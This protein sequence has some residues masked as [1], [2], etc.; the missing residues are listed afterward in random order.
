MSLPAETPARESTQAMDISEAQ[1]LIREEH[2]LHVPKDDPVM[3]LVTLL[4][5]FQQDQNAQ[6]G[7]TIKDASKDF[8]A[9]IDEMRS[10]MRESVGD[11]NEAVIKSNLA[12][13]LAEVTE[14]ARISNDLLLSVQKS[15][16]D[17]SKAMRKRLFLFALL[18]SF[19]TLCNGLAAAVIIFN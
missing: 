18:A 4:N 15:N 16:E 13:V 10:A 7:E 12:Q 1:R 14:K 19:L 11:L 9:I 5:R 3:I 6:L 8:T 2:H 17:H